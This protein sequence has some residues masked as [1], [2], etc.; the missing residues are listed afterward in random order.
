MDLASLFLV[1]DF[2]KFSSLSVT[3]RETEPSKSDRKLTTLSICIMTF[4]RI[5]INW[6]IHEYAKSND[7]VG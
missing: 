2:E 3:S 6:T 4:N 1:I 7:P 5:D